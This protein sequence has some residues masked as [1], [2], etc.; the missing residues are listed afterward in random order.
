[1]NIN[2]K[3]RCR[4]TLMGLVIGD[5]L[6]AK[7]EGRPPGSFEPLAMDNLGDS[8]TSHYTDDS[9]MALA[10]ADSIAKVG[11]DINDQARRYVDWFQKGTYSAHG[12][13]YGSGRITREAIRMFIETQDAFHSGDPNESASGNGSIMRL[14]PVPIRYHDHYPNNIPEL[15]RLAEESSL[16]THARTMSIGLPL[17]GTRPECVD[18]RRGPQCG[19]FADMGAVGRIERHQAA[20]S[21]DLCCGPGQFQGEG[22]ACYSRIGLG[23]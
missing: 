11:W 18:P 7:L 3:D 17:Y 13:C 16:T 21:L 2:V 12:Y 20:A 15:A 23:C 8:L 5:I 22:T 1:M 14:A 4:G 6:G 19:T 10:L 9:A